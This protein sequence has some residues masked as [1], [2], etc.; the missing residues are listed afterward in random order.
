[1]ED[2]RQ[3]RK[4]R[5]NYEWYFAG[6]SE[7]GADGKF[8]D[9]RR[10]FAVKAERDGDGEGGDNIIDGDINYGVYDDYGE[11]FHGSAGGGD[12]ESG[13]DSAD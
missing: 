10:K 1:M 12:E 4:E 8:C 5:E 2:L 11:R 6:R 7:F 9:D 3:G 13:S